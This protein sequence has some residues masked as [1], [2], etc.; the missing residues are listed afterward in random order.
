MKAV[1][2]EDL[3]G[4]IYR[5][6][7]RLA[8]LGA[9]EAHPATLLL[10]DPQRADTWRCLLC[11]LSAA[12][13]LPEELLMQA[14]CFP[15]VVAGQAYDWLEEYPPAWYYRRENEVVKPDRSYIEEEGE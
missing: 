7:W 11:V 13:T 1:P 6:L 8:T 4:E 14:G 15:H 10:P 5:D 3:A 9:C 12:E 2:L